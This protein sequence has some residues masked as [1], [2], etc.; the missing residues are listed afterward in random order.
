MLQS[1]PRNARSRGRFVFFASAT[2]FGKSVSS[3]LSH[4]KTRPAN[5][6]RQRPKAAPKSQ[7]FTH[8]DCNPTPVASSK[9]YSVRATPKLFVLLPIDCPAIYQNCGTA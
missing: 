7:I 2:D 6:T 1:V 8:D 4:A 9:Y 3:L 5:T